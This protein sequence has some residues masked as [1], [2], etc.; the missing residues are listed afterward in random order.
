[1]ATVYLVRHGK[2]AASFGAH[3]DPGLAPE[4][5]RQ[6]EATAA[7]LAALGPLPIYTSPLARARETATPLARRWAR[8]PIV[9]PRVAE[10]P[11]PGL[12]LEDRAVWI[13][14]VMGRRWSE[15]DPALRDWRD[16]LVSYVAG[17]ADDAVV[18]SHFIAINAVVGAA[19]G[20]DRVVTFHPDHA[21]VTRCA[22]GAGAA[23]EVV[24]LGEEADTEVR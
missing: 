15:L 20:D 11:T 24:T 6:A 14:G 12:A 18:F 1:M 8:E 3:R 10:L 9:E 16:A 13:R 2:A 23:L 4:G 7:R 17:L 19:R 21:S 22:T 5:E